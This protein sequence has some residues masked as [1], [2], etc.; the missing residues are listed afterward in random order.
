MAHWVYILYSKQLD[1][2]Y[3]GETENVDVRVEQHNMHLFRGSFTKQA[4]DRVL[5]TTIACRDRAHARAV[6]AFIKAR[7]R[8]AFIERVMSDAA[9]RIGLAKKF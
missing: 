8:R 2:Y 3:V 1:R 7:K 6:E 4:S 5:C 9:L